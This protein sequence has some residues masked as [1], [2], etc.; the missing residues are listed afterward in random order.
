MMY[1]IKKEG[2]YQN[3]ANSNLD[4]N[5]KIGYD[6]FPLV[7]DADVVFAYTMDYIYMY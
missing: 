1:I 6:C 3:N 5:W 2:L 4:Y 7:L